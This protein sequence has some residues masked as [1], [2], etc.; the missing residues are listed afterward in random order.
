[1]VVCFGLRRV[2]TFDKT[3]TR[4]RNTGG[5][6]R[7]GTRQVRSPKIS[8]LPSHCVFA[9]CRVRAFILL[10]HLKLLTAVVK[11]RFNL[12]NVC[13]KNHVSWWENH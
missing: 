7:R 1:M 13:D 10:A 9:G 5:R 2:S 3:H 6:A 12:H 8:A 4:D 11:V